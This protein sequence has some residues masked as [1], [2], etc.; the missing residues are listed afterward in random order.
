MEKQLTLNG[1]NYLYKENFDV[2][3]TLSY[4]NDKWG[5]WEIVRE[6]LSNVIDS[7]SGDITKIYIE[8]SEGKHIIHDLGA[9][10]P[11]FYAKRI[12]ASCKKNS[13]DSIGQFGEGIKLA[14]LTCIRNNIAVMLGSQNWLIVPYINHIED[15][16]VLFYDIYVANE[17]ISGSIV[18]IEE[19]AVID[20]IFNNLAEYFLTYN[21]N[22]ALF[23]DLKSGIY[24][25]FNGKCRL[26]NKGVYVKD[27]NGLF[28]YA[29]CIENI[30]RD[31]NIISNDDLAF[32]V[33]NIYED[34]NNEKI[35]ESVLQTSVMPYEAKKN[36]I[37]FQYSFCTNYP[38][39][40][41]TA[42]ENLFGCNSCISTN[43][44][45]SRE[46]EALGYDPIYN[47]D[48]SVLRILKDVGIKEDVNCLSDDYE[49]VWADTLTESEKE[50]LNRLPRLAKLAGFDD[51][52]K[53]IKVYSQ[54]RN[55]EN[56]SGCF[57]PE[58]QEICLKKDII[59]EGL[60]KALKTY[61]H[62]S[63]H[64]VTGF[65]DL[66]RGFA[67]NLCSRLTELL[68]KYSNETG[69]E[70]QV[71]V[72]NNILELPEDVTLSA[73]D[74]TAYISA[75][76]NIFMLKVGKYL[77]K[78]K[79]KEFIPPTT[80]KRKVSIKS[81]IFSIQIPEV[82]KNLFILNKNNKCAFTVQ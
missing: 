43:G 70:Y 79:L 37:E 65:D 8:H 20:K 71:N 33:G 66:N 31:R 49:F 17:N 41:K 10:Y 23:G 74:L 55:H 63:T 26:Y 11:I 27:I 4:E 14:L 64:C 80:F 22:P 50:I 67:D 16:D 44:I 59:D 78:T 34:V 77:L 25:K 62:E 9:G 15:Q 6:F 60:D 75:I 7:V 61:L 3:L 47:L 73:K 24:P 13:S 12:G 2:N 69:I 35:I 81:G 54:Y 51:L 58:K 29:V 38:E 56:V 53:A 39:I 42:F 46:C 18:S 28:S 82:I 72:S 5:A 57:I 48:Y 1:I 36:L 52:P 30:N 45:A 21:K 19:S 40:W 76:G 32:K 68:L